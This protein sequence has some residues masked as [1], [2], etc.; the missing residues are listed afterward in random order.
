LYIGRS[1]GDG[2]DDFLTAIDADVCLHAKE[3]LIALSS[4]VHIRIVAFVLVLG[5]RRCTDDGRID[6]GALTHLDP[7]RLEV[8]EHV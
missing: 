6:D 3:P 1:R 4:L 2:V 5:R 8:L 7:V